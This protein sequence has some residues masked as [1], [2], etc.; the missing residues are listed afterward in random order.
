[1]TLGCRNSMGTLP[2]RR[3]FQYTIQAPW[4]GAAGATAGT[5]QARLPLSPWAIVLAEACFHLRL[6][7]QLIACDFC[8]DELLQVTQ[9]SGSTWRWHGRRWA[10]APTD[11]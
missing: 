3:T 6:P 1:M 10:V 11:P 5:G 2:L 9:E 7:L 8:H 4:E